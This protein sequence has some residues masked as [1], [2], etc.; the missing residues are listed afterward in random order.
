MKKITCSLLIL[1]FLLLFSV[2][3][4]QKKPVLGP[5]IFMP[6][7]EWDF[8]YIPQNTAVSH[9]FTIKNVGDD[10]LQIIKVRPGCAC[11]Y[12]PLKKDILPPKDSTSLEVTFNSR[13]YQGPKSLM[14]AIFS[15]DTSNSPDINFTANIENEFP[16]FQVEPLQVKF[17]TLRAGK[18]SP[19]KVTISN[20]S[21]SAL[22]LS[23][24]EKPK[25]FIDF[26]IS[27]SILNPKEKAEISLQVN[28]K[29]TPGPFLTNLT[30][31]FSGGSTGQDTSKTR[32]TLP[33]SGNILSK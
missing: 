17:D 33:I 4:G 19:M 23:V 6:E 31:D 1:L 7:K 9:F 30:L 20:K 3:Q 2:S 16:L 11:T 21:A 15:S 26:Q 5:K 14:V 28:R 10:T 18:T 25:D 22:N 32:Y 12:A 13:S 27:K 8:G 24:A 29:A